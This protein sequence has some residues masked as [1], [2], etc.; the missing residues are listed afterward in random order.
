MLHGYKTIQ[1]V[2]ESGNHAAG[3]RY[4]IP[5]TPIYIY[6]YKLEKQES[7]HALE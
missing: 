2:E 1:E 4:R 7:G 5:G 6:I 3:T